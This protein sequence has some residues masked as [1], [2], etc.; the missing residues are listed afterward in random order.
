MRL[1]V[2]DVFPSQFY[3]SLASISPPDS[4]QFY[5]SPK[6]MGPPPLGLP[7]AQPVEP[8]ID[9]DLSS[10]RTL[11]SPS[12]SG[13]NA[14]D[15]VF[16]PHGIGES[17]YG[18]SSTVR[19]HHQHS[20]DNYARSSTQNPLGQW[21]Q[22]ND[23][24]W[25]PKDLTGVS[26][27]KLQT[28]EIGNRHAMS[29]GT[30]YRQLNPSETGSVHFGVPHSDSGYGTRRS[31]GNTSVFSADVT[32]RDQDCQSLAGHVENFQ[33]FHGFTEIGQP[34][35]SRTNEMWPHSDPISSESN[36]PGLTCPTCH[37]PVKT[38][39]ELK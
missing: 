35:D 37:K 9:I 21:Y 24:P 29:F 38:Q 27:E 3:P 23:G 20:I 16:Q 34:R 18:S 25:V 33:P 4:G 14:W 17:T 1:A 8:G 12:T 39:S 5:G 32:E 19:T 13:S 26:E 11:P 10:R 7:P 30:Q 31:V 28:R 15:P 6:E 2:S 22:E 36:S